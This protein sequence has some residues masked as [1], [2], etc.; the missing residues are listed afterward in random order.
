M[1][2]AMMRGGRMGGRRRGRGGREAY[3]TTS[4]NGRTVGPNTRDADGGGVGGMDPMMTMMIGQSAAQGVQDG[5]QKATDASNRD[6]EEE[7]AAEA[8]RRASYYNY[9]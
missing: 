7:R 2:P 8:R 9:V 3:P 6:K 4:M 1:L 5:I